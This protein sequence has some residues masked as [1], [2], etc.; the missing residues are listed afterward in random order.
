[1][2][3]KKAAL[4][5]PY[6]DLM[7]GGERHVLSMMKTLE[8]AG[9][10]ISI[11]WDDNLNNQIENKLNIPFITPPLYKENIFKNNTSLITKLKELSD[12]DIL[13]YVTDGSYFFSTAKKTIAFCM[14]PQKNLYKMSLMN[15]LKTNNYHFIS[16]SQFTKNN[17][18]K[19]G[20]TSDVVYPCLDNPFTKIDINSLHKEKI[21]ISVGRFFKH[22]HAKRQDKVIAAFKKLREKNNDL[23]K[24][25]LILA[26]SL[27]EEDKDY[28]AEL[29]TMIGNDKYIQLLPN[30]S[31]EELLELYKKSQF[32][33]H[34]AG[35]DIDENKYPERV[36][37]LGITPLEAM[38]AGCI[39]MCYK[40]GGPK[41]IIQNGHNGFLF[42][43]EKELDEQ[44]KQ[45]LSDIPLQKHL[46]KNAYEYIQTYFRYESLQKRMWEVLNI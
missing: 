22:L 44:M 30:I 16:N 3:R 11:F 13:I 1:M 14:V 17:L 36:E 10:E 15:K 35:Y 5:D 20:L 43:S 27:K 46:K 18:E 21:I 29:Q 41:E 28:F 24:Y 33:W 42:S 19:W 26:G 23:T 4:Y 31:F 38:A 2:K 32:Y 7:G 34:F 6:L 12:I 8:D 9:Y 25:T 45:I 37:H 40:A 39:T